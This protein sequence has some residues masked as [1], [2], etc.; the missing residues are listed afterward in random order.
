MTESIVKATPELSG[1]TP[2]DLTSAAG[3][4][5]IVQSDV[6]GDTEQRFIIDADGQI[7]W[8][9]GAATGDTTLRRSAADTLRVGSDLHV[10]GNL[11]IGDTPSVA[12]GLY[13]DGGANDGGAFILT[14]SAAKIPL[15]ARGAASQT[16]NLTEW[17]DS[18]GTVLARVGNDGTVSVVD[19]EFNLYAAATQVG[20]MF[21]VGATDL[22]IRQMVAAGEGELRNSDNDGLVRWDNTGLGFFGAT[23]AAQP[24]AISDPSGGGVQDAESRTAIAA[25]IDALQTLGLVAT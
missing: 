4:D 11:G 5:P 22:V 15:V 3:T 2:L 9:S 8:G 12:Y 16:A 7:T 20:R 24:A 1:T 14:G 25:I 17:Q 10:A 13:I 23:P 18:A 19:A 21:D 6:T